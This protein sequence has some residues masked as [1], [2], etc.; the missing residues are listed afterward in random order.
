MSQPDKARS[1][2]DSAKSDAGST[3]RDT[4]KETQKSSETSSISERTG[5]KLGEE[6]DV[7]ISKSATTAQATDVTSNPD[8]NLE[9]PASVELSEQL[10]KLF[11][12]V[13]SAIQDSRLVQDVQMQLGQLPGRKFLNGSDTDGAAATNGSAKIEKFKGFT[14]SDTPHGEATTKV[15]ES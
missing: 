7:A 14:T 9:A 3:V 2:E 15:Y 4:P 13:D 8:Q 10:R 5:L 1:V 12:S 11:G 6:T